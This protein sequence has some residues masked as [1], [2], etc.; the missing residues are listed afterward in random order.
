MSNPAPTDHIAHGTPAALREY[1]AENIGLASIQADLVLTYA[2]L[3]DD[4]GL[5][6]A[7]RCFTSYTKAALATFSDLKSATGKART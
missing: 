3:G 5:E 7:L 1:I 6:Y 2:A 4:K